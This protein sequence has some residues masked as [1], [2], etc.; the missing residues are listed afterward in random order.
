M[1]EDKTPTVTVPYDSELETAHKRLEEAISGEFGI[2]V[3]LSRREAVIALVKRG[4]KAVN[5]D[6]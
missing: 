1:S 5:E 2:D 3:S 6:R 4:A